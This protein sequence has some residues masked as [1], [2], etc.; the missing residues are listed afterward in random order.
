[1]LFRRINFARIVRLRIA[2][3][4]TKNNAKLKPHKIYKHLR[5]GA[6]Y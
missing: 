1:M 5:H 2:G 3:I 6:V 4:Y